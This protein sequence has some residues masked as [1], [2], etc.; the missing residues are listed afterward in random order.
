[1]PGIFISYRHEDSIAYAGRVY[2]HLTNHFGRSNVFMDV[3]NI[4]PGLDFVEVLQ[5]TVSSCDA[6]VVV[7]GRSWLSATDE[8]G[9]RRLDAPDD[10]VRL[11][12]AA[13][14]ERKVR[15]VPV[16]VGGARMPR[17]Q[18]L[19]PALAGLARRNSLELSDLAFHE[20]VKRLI[21][22]LERS[23]APHPKSASE[24]VRDAPPPERPQQVTDA[25]AVTPVV[26]GTGRESAPQ[27]HATDVVTTIAGL[28]RWRRWTLLYW[29]P[30]IAGWI[31]RLLFFPFGLMTLVGINAWMQGQFRSSTDWSA[32]AGFAVGSAVCWLVARW[33]DGRGFARRNSVRAR[34]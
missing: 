25:V 27:E 1:M 17:S 23:V 9:H 16:L 21:D 12:I 29:P 30:N 5:Q 2:D 15:V 11:E 31:F 18:D 8:D 22:A 28:S 13:A 26:E 6:L 20:S 4:E 10:L 33:V 19:P 14:L 3:D 24:P 32:L 7:I 34:R